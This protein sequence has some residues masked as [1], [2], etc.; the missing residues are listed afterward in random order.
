MKL[1]FHHINV[2]SEDVD[3]LH[4]FYTKVLGMDD[5]PAVSFP[6]TPAADGKGYDGKITFATEGTMQMHIAEQDL[7]VATKNGH[8][9][10]PVERGHFAFRTDDIAAFIALLKEQ[11]IPYSDYG[12]TFSQEWHQVFFR[13]P[14]GNVIEVHGL[15]ADEA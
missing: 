6:R 7:D 3:G 10:N 1:E 15:V 13:D 14:A 8:A 5:I 9:I 11:D 12:T 4:A 2:V